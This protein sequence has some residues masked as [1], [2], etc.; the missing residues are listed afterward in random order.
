MR[1]NYTRAT[2]YF[3]VYFMSSAMRLR[4]LESA[5][6]LRYLRVLEEFTVPETERVSLIGLCT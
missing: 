6:R 3:L 1:P 4:D 2:I 5:E